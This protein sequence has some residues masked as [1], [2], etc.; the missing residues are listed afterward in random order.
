M[1]NIL[2]SSLLILSSI[3]LGN[4]VLYGFRKRKVPGVLEFSFL[5]LAMIIHSLGYALELLSGSQEQMYFWIRIEYIGAAFYPFLIML[6]ASHYTDEKNIANKY[7]LTL[8]LTIN[9]VTFVL[10]NTNSY[11]WLYYASVRVNVTPEFNVLALEKGMWYFV[12]VISLYLSILY[13]IVIF[14]IKLKQARGDYRKKIMYILIGVSIPV[15]T[16]LLYMFNLG[17]IYIDISPFSYFFMTLFIIFGLFRHD[18]LLLTPVTYEMVFNSI[19]EA[20]LVVDEE[21]ILINF[22]SA[23]KEF[24]PSLTNIKI[25]E[26]IHKIAE[27]K[28]YGFDSNQSIYEVNEKILSFKVN[29]IKSNRVCVYVVNDITES[30]RAKKQLEIMATED[31]LTGLYNRRYFMEYMEKSARQGTCAMIDIDFFKVI[32][33]TYGH[34][35][36]DKVLSYFGEEIKKIFHNQIACRYGGEEFVIFFENLDRNE[37]YNMVEIMREKMNKEDCAIKFTFSAGLAEYTEG[38]ILNVLDKADQYLYKAK[39]NG[40]NQT[41]Y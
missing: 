22:N 10:V 40:R 14:S 6:F 33:D 28:K 11:H 15:I 1:T 38:N 17:P 16:L 18:I 27:L 30:E 35:E 7:I 39:T 2:L 4:L 24:F 36:G 20:V 41:Q 8:M 25:G 37:T 31:A 9:I 13:S 32:N 34:V 5:M 3:L 19:G 12:Q 29:Y 26:S 21:G 23:S